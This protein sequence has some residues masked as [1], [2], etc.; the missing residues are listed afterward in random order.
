MSKTKE[1]A[2]SLERLQR[3]LHYCP[4]SGEFTWTDAASKKMRKKRAG[5][6]RERGWRAIGIDGRIYRSGRLAWFYMTGEWPSQ[7]IDHKNRI[8]DDDRFSNLRCASYSEQNYNR[9]I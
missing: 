4:D 9:T 3:I 1:K 2:L 6:T 8:R 5:T 7:T